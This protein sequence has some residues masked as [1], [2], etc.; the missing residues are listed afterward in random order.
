MEQTPIPIEKIFSIWWSFAWRGILVTLFFAIV[1]GAIGG[2]VMAWLGR[3]EDSGPV[4]GIIGWLVSFPVS[5]WALKAALT[6]KHGGY[7]VTLVRSS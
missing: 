1:L 7:S 4:G 6:V 5:V 2:F 3:L